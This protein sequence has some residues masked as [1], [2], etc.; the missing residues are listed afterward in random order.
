MPYRR[1]NYRRNYR[2]KYR[3]PR[4]SYGL[5]RKAYN[6]AKYSQRRKELKYHTTAFDSNVDGDVDD[7]GLL[8][9]VSSIGLGDTNNDRDGN[10]IY[11]TSFKLRLCIQLNPSATET[12]VRVIIFQWKHENPI[13]ISDYLAVVSIDSFKSDINR[14]LS[15]TLYDHVYRVTDSGGNK[16]MFTEIKRNLRQMITYPD[17]GT[18]ANKNQ[19][20]VALLSNQAVN[21]PFVQFESRLYFKDA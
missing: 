8:V 6:L 11:P 21:F 16:N 12:F 13:S 2:R 14:Y 15:K 3:R 7:T 19:T 1:R 9:N 10:V 20:F 17:A 5:A 4:S 18:N